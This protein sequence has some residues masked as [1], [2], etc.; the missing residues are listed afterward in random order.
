MIKVSYEYPL[1]TI[2]SGA[3]LGNGITGETLWG[4]KNV[5]NITLGS[6]N[7]WDHRGG[8]AWTPGQNYKATKAALEAGDMGRIREI[9]ASD[10]SS[11]VKRPSLIPVGRLVITLPE[12][13][14][15][16]RYEQDLAA[17][18][19]KVIYEQNDDEK[20]LT[21]CADMSMHDALAGSGLTDEMQIT[22]IP[23]YELTAKANYK[24]LLSEHSSLAE[25]GFEAPE[26]FAAEN[27]AGFTQKMPDDP[28]FTMA[29][30]KFDDGTFTLIF[31]RDFSGTPET[32]QCNDFNTIRE[33]S[34]KFFADYW[35]TVPEIKY[36][37]KELEELYYHGLFK[38]GIMTNPAGCP[39]GLQGPWIEDDRLPPWQG[40]Y[41]FNINVQM[42]HLP[43]LK[44]GRFANLKNFFDMVLSWKDKLRYNAKCFVGIDDGYMLPH[45]VNDR[46]VCMGGF[47]TG[48]ID[49]ACAA[50]VAG[51]MFD[52]CEYSC[53][54]D[55]LKNEVYDF[56]LGVLRVYRAMM[57][58][59][60]DG[61]LCLPLTISPEYRGSSIDAW[62][63]NASFQLAATHQLAANILR[64]G[65]LLGIPADPMSLEIR[66]NLP[67]YSITENQLSRDTGEPPK[68]VIAL[69]EGLALEE[70]H[71]HHSHLAGICPFEVIDPFA[72]ENEE[73]VTA[74]IEQWTV[75]GM[76]LWTG[77][78]V[79]W[80][81]QIFSRCGNGDA[82]ALML[83]IWKDCFTN[84]GGGSLHDG[85]Y[86]G[87]TY[88][89]QIRGEVMQM[90]GGM[91]A[92]TAIQD[93][94]MHVFDGQIRVFYGVPPRLNDVSF[95]DMFAPG[96][97]K[98]SGSITRKGGTTV[99]VYAPRDTDLRLKV[100]NS[101]EF[102][103]RIKA[104]ETITLHLNDGKLVRA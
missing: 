66:K 42:C 25:H 74:S 44:A 39:A 89:S 45:A 73:L 14:E 54:M 3:M 49:H 59:D 8:M 2:T 90:D 35:S 1:T 33:S 10:M 78:C 91:G 71:R 16:L 72:P 81:S 43:G 51:M 27:I 20:A 30:R 13:A 61:K 57:D 60:A 64:A 52:Y 34:E 50:W 7:L 12:N 85:R 79:P 76:G 67:L 65:K 21:F 100:R 37:V 84:Y 83:K 31:R 41:H 26:K 55:Y 24:W 56:M 77:W 62:G 75:L 29:Y 86:K 5:L 87:V 9:F 101:E 6:G 38:Y 4:E 11:G 94:F 47:W 22:V 92:V 99:S 103:G 28:S 32:L 63:R 69:W 19:V 82:S 40:D 68:K 18:I 15:L 46:A 88:F 53:D 102:S 96:G 36:P 98:V 80:A 23:S 104:G 70:S 48:C 58:H 17:G 97:L 93:Q 95:K